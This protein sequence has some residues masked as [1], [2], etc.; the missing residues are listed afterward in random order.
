MSRYSAALLLVAAVLVPAVLAATVGW[1]EERAKA[2]HAWPHADG[3]GYAGVGPVYGW[4]DVYVTSANTA[5]YQDALDAI[6]SWRALREGELWWLRWTT[7]PSEAKAEIIDKN[8]STL[9][10]DVHLYICN[11]YFIPTPLRLHADE[12]WATTIVTDAAGDVR[13]TDADGFWAKR[14]GVPFAK[15]TACLNSAFNNDKGTIAHELGHVL[16]L[17][18]PTV[19]GTACANTG[20]DTIMAYNYSIWSQQ[21]PSDLQPT[22]NDVYGPWACNSAFAGGLAYVY[23]VTLSR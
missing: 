6:E 16:G 2:N 22:A 13:S 23:G 14:P 11:N 10:G 19:S 9:F 18:H 21:H 1:N 3:I 4:V 17:D 8:T 12:I 5:Q 7:T 20:V 15:A